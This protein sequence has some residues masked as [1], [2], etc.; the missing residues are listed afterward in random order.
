MRRDIVNVAVA[1]SVHRVLP[2]HYEVVH[3]QIVEVRPMSAVSAEVA[4]RIR[5]ELAFYA[6]SSRL[7]RA[8]SDMLF[9]IPLAEDE[10]RNREPDAAFISY[11]RWPENRPLPYRGNPVDVM[12]NVVVEVASP[13]DDA[14][15]LLAKAH[16]YL[17][18]GAE[19]V[20]VVFPR[21]R[22]VY[23]YTQPNAAPQVFTNEDTLNGGTAMPGF[24]V[25]V[26]AL[27]PAM[28]LEAEPDDE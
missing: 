18:G 21:V 4:N 14:E 6:R 3:G 16:E 5:D 26:S 23:A 17:R 27:F 13:T 1:D 12:P 25:A 2:E 28:T 22:Q 11:E 19:L 9:R 24:A 15:D 7:G 20:W 8:R 10:T